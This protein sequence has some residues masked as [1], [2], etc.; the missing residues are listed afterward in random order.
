MLAAKILAL[1]TPL[2]CRSPRRTPV[3]LPQPVRHRI[4]ELP[5]RQARHF[6]PHRPL[7]RPRL[8]RIKRLVN[9]SRH[10]HRIL[11]VAQF[12]LVLRHGFIN[13]ARQRRQRPVPIKRFL[14]FIIHPHAL[15]PVAL[16]AKLPVNRLALHQHLP[17]HRLCL[18]LHHTPRRHGEQQ[19]TKLQQHLTGVNHPQ[20]NAA[21]ACLV[22]EPKR[23]SPTPPE[24][25]LLRPPDLY[26]F[27]SLKL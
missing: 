22:S 10:R 23:T 17:T 27:R 25:T 4:P 2:A 13:P 18:Q 3:Q 7:P 15:L 11:A 26:P 16:D 21:E 9:V 5:H 20:P 19:E 6:R 1:Q 12:R 14:V 8:R 24:F